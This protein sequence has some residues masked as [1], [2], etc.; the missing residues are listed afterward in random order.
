VADA[1]KQYILTHRATPLYKKVVLGGDFR[2]LHDFKSAFPLT[3]TLFQELDSK[4]ELNHAVYIDLTIGER[5]R[6][7]ELH[8]ISYSAYW[9]LDKVDRCIVATAMYQDKFLAISTVMSLLIRAGMPLNVYWQ[10]TSNPWL[11]SFM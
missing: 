10:G 11:T 7:R 5:E 1:Y 2:Y 4:Q 3:P 9:L 6:G 8:V